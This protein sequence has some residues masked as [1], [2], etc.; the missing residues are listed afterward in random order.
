MWG[1]KKKLRKQK[2]QNW[3]LL[4]S[5]KGEKI[6]Q[7]RKL[8]IAEIENVEIEECLYYNLYW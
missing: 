5:T 3:R 2:P 6:G 8:K 1:H 4:S 7:N